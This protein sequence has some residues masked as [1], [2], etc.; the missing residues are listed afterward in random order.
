MTALPTAEHQAMVQLTRSRKYELA[1]TAV[2]GVTLAMLSMFTLGEVFGG[3][4]SGLAH[5]VQLVPLAILIALGWRFPYSIGL[6]LIG[7]GAALTLAYYI[8]SADSSIAT[9][10]KLLVGALFLLPPLLSGACFVLAGNAQRS[11]RHEH[12]RGI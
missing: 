1:A 8:D 12:P 7:I 3:D 11:R 9:S 5:L 2:A 6:V 4:W 10:E